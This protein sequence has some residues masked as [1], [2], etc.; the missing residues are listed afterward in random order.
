MKTIMKT[1]FMILIACA[2]NIFL[3]WLIQNASI[4]MKQPRRAVNANGIRLVQYEPPPEAET[5]VKKTSPEP[6]IPEKH[7]VNTPKI[8]FDRKRFKPK[9]VQLKMEIKQPDFDIPA[10]LKTG[11]SIQP[12]VKKK[13]TVEPKAKVAKKEISPPSSSVPARPPK[14]EFSIHEVDKKP[15][16]LE[17]V[18]PVYPYRARRRN[19]NGTVEVKFLVSKNG[20]VKKLTVLQSAPEG[21]FEKSVI[22]AVSRWKFKPGYFRGKAVSTWVI[23][24]IHFKLSS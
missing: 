10:E 16:I 21:I 22:E 24:P 2:V 8:S 15:R 14:S 3:L 5:D 6:P 12:P 18:E 11:I 19:I 17:K 20:D 13:Q 7:P 1:G 23:L 4:E 9:T